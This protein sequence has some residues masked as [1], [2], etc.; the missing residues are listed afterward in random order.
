MRIFI[1]QKFSPPCGIPALVDAGTHDDVPP[2]RTPA[3]TSQGDTAPP[4]YD[5]SSALRSE[6]EPDCPPPF[7]RFSFRQV[8]M[9]RV[10]ASCPSSLRRSVT[11]PYRPPTRTTSNRQRVSAG[12]GGQEGRGCLRIP[13]FPVHVARDTNVSRPNCSTI[14]T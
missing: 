2:P 11:T 8:S 7:P 13:A 14:R 9:R 10:T 4:P 12:F 3:S 1:G 5:P 6:A